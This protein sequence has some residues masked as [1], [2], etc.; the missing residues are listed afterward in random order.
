MYDLHHLPA[1]EVLT[2]LASSTQGLSTQE[3]GRRLR[4]YGANR[5]EAAPR[6][7][8]L[9]RLLKEFTGLFSIVLWIA[10]G[11]AFLV[12][13]LEPGQGT[14][15]IGSAVVMVIIVSGLFSFW[16]EFC[17]EQALAALQRL[18]PR[19]IT[20]VRDGTVSQVVAEAL[21]PG[22]LIRL[23]QGE[24]VP[25]DCRLIESFGVRINSATVAGET[26]AQPRDSEPSS[27]E[28]PLH[29]KNILLA[30]TSL[31]SGECT[32]VVYATGMRTEFGRIAHLTLAGGAVVSP[33]RREVAH[34]SRV[35]TLLAV[36]IG[37]LFFTV[38]WWV[39]LPLWQSFIFAIDII[40]AMVPEGLQPTLTLALVL[41]TK[42]MA[43]RHVLIRHLATVETLGATT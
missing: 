12:A 19:Q 2:T 38:G 17:A 33:L 32:A 34:L 15:Q 42:R 25:S 31:I 41:A 37:V 30:G 13:L 26:G 35:I 40:V 6:R 22:D 3:A 21:V 4:E 20:V 24:S 10:A 7:H 43:K 14:A 5:I 23:T 16:Q 27:E 18:L 28:D 1:T 29:C 9:A 8:L 39:G 11:L 36:I